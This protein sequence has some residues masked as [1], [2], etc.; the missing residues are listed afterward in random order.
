ML[1]MNV[2]WDHIQLKWK[3]KLVKTLFDIRRVKENRVI[4]I[5]VSLKQ[6]AKYKVICL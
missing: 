3:I 2:H 5:F 6:A 1:L 4:K